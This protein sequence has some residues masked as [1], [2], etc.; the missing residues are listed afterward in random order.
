[1]HDPGNV[2]LIGF[3][4]AF[5]LAAVTMFF[6]KRAVEKRGEQTPLTMKHI[7]YTAS[8]AGVLIMGGIAKITVFAE[9]YNAN[10]I[11]M[12]V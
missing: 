4:F 12:P 3:A 6:A 11:Y 8:A 7:G 10:S 5:I 2:Y 9:F 1:M